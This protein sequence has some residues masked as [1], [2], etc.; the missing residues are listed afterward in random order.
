MNI[1]GR[2]EPEQY[3]TCTGGVGSGCGGPSGSSGGGGGFTGVVFFLDGIQ[4]L[5]VTRTDEKITGTRDL[6]TS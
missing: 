4:R 1:K 2:E 3:R 5:Q 6:L